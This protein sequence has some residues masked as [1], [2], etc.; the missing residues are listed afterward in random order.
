MATIRQ[1]VVFATEARLC[2]RPHRPLDETGQLFSLQSTVSKFERYASKLEI[3]DSSTIELLPFQ[4]R[5]HQWFMMVTLAPAL[6]IPCIMVRGSERCAVVYDRSSLEISVRSIFGRFI[7]SFELFKWRSKSAAVDPGSLWRPPAAAFSPIASRANSRSP[8][9]D[10]ASLIGGSASSSTRAYSR[11]AWLRFSST[12]TP[13][14][15]VAIAFQ[16]A[17]SRLHSGRPGCLL[18]WMA[19]WWRLPRVAAI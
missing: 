16:G 15:S 5:R 8:V 11:A 6:Q 3:P 19:N 18:E 12:V 10:G 17:A 7:S 9:L 13:I 2:L 4:E 14:P 1:V